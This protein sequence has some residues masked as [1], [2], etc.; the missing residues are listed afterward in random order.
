[1]VGGRDWNYTLPSIIFSPLQKELYQGRFS[2][3]RTPGGGNFTSPLNNFYPPLDFSRGG[4][5]L[6]SNCQE[7]GD[8]QIIPENDQIL[9]FWRPKAV[10]IS[11]FAPYFFTPP[12][13]QYLLPLKLFQGG[14]EGGKFLGGR[15]GNNLRTQD[16][17][18]IIKRKKVHF[19]G[20]LIS[21]KDFLGGGRG[22]LPTR[23]AKVWGGVKG[24]PP[25]IICRENREQGKSGFKQQNLRLDFK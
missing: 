5:K 23:K 25:P 21:R 15:G 24:D 8:N 2:S 4:G 7:E 17:R 20:D 11:V 10:N 9:A 12:P 16:E 3:I 6:I 13:Q 19:H 14:V 22:Y 18:F 1:M